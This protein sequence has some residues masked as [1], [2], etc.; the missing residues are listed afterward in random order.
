MSHHLMGVAEIAELLG[1]TRQ[2]V[3]Q[4]RQLDGFPE[5]TSELAIGLVWESADIERWAR[6]TGRLE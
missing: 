2:R 3:H 4:L 5:P 1:V 6:E